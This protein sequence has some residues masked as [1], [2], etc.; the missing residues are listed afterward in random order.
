VKVT[1]GE[2]DVIAME[3]MFAMPI[4]DK[5]AMSMVVVPRENIRS[6][7]TA[8]GPIPISSRDLQRTFVDESVTLEPQKTTG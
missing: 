1:D 3:I 8:A 5:V 4:Q 2:P 6:V 7:R